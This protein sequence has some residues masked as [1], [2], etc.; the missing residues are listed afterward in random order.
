MRGASGLAARLG[1]SRLVIGLTVV[2]LATSAP[3]LAVTIDAVMGGQP[4]LAIGNVVGSNIAMV[5]LILGASAIV[6]RLAISAQLV[7]LDIPLLVGASVLL[8]VLCLD[9]SVSVVTALCCWLSRSDMR[10]SSWRLA[11]GKGP[12]STG[13]P[14]RSPAIGATRGAGRQ[15]WEASS[16]WWWREWSC[17]SWRAGL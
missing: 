4:D 2:A 7:R 3:E 14:A 16:Q 1:L 9:G 15:P 12:E 6:A 13:G 10:A 11:A 5:L 8:L 17:W